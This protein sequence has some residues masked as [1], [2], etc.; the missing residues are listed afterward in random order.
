MISAA[1]QARTRPTMRTAVTGLLQKTITGV[2]GTQRV[3]T[4]LRTTTTDIPHTGIQAIVTRRM[5]THI[6]LRV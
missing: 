5:R 3:N 1:T 2:L 6:F 4:A